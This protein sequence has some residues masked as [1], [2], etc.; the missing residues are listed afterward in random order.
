MAVRGVET[1]L[2]RAADLIVSIQSRIG[3]VTGGKSAVG[4]ISIVGAWSLVS[5]LVVAIR[6]TV[7]RF[8]VVVTTTFAQTASL[9]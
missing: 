4:A 6:S 1:L 8:V 7:V 9:L 5:V 2:R 3:V